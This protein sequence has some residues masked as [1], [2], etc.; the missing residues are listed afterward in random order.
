MEDADEDDEDVDELEGD[1]GDETVIE[2]VFR[3]A[4]LFDLLPSKLINST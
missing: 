3:I 1:D 4:V 2:L